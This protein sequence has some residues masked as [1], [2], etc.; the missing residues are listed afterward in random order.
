M[1]EDDGAHAPLLMVHRKI[2]VPLAI[3]VMALVASVGDV[4]LAVP[5]IT[6]HE[7]VPIDGTL[8]AIVVV[9]LLAQKV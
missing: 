8:P 6:V 5:L 9:G 1:V 4:M 7:P 2:L 3:A